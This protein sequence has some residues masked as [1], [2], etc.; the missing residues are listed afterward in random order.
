MA[1]SAERY[2]QLHHHTAHKDVRR[3]IKHL[4]DRTVLGEDARAGALGLVASRGLTI[5]SVAILDQASSQQIDPQSDLQTH[6]LHLSSPGLSLPSL[7]PAQMS[8]L[9]DH[10]PLCC[11]LMRLAI[12]R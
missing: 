1:P 10:R 6:V 3:T 7:R 2:C 8:W 12:G 9:S 5:I 4:A 11:W